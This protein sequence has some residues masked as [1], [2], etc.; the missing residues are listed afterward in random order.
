MNPARVDDDEPDT[1]CSCGRIGATVE[2]ALMHH[3]ANRRYRVPSPD[4][5]A[6]E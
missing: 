2:R 6:S 4:R 5:G 1:F 3:I